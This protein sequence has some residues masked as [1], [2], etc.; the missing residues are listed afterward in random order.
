MAKRTMPFA[1]RPCA[2]PVDLLSRAGRSAF[3]FLPPK[4]P[5]DISILWMDEDGAVLSRVS[6]VTAYEAT[7]FKLHELATDERNSHGL[8]KDITEAAAA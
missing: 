6:G 1:P 5:E 4:G 2:H 3:K 7:L 8:I